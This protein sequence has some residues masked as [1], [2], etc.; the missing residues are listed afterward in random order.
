MLDFRPSATDVENRMLLANSPA[1]DEQKANFVFH[2]ST[3]G[4]SSDPSGRDVSDRIRFA[5]GQSHSWTAG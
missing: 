3:K 1:Q 2:S 4:M 5:F